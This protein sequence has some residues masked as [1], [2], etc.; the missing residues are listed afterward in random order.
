MTHFKTCRWC[1]VEM[2]R[3]YRNSGGSMQ[4][5]DRKFKGWNC[6]IC[7]REWDESGKLQGIAK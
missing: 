3:S 7:G 5:H 1:K 2:Q 4:F 6:L